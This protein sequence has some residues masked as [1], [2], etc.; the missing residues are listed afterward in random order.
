MEKLSGS[1]PV[2]VEMEI[3]YAFA[4]I[5]PSSFVLLRLPQPVNCSLCGV[6]ETKHEDKYVF[7][8]H[9]VLKVRFEREKS[10]VCCA[11]VETLQH[12][13]RVPGPCILLCHCGRV[14]HFEGNW[15][16][17]RKWKSKF[18]SFILDKME[19]R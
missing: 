16:I 8:V 1:K 17:G 9:F 19:I 18:C 3:H 5:A 4:A 13:F 12:C 7:E 15:D 14:L 11:S 10:W 2:L 6:V